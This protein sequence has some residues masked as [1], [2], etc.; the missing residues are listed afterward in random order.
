MISAMKETVS[1]QVQRDEPCVFCGA[2]SSSPNHA[3]KM[4]C[5]GT[6]R[7]NAKRIRDGEPLPSTQS[8]VVQMFPRKSP[9]KHCGTVESKQSF[10]AKE[11]CSKAC[12]NSAQRAAEPVTLYARKNPCLRCG[13]TIVNAEK[14]V[15]TEYCSSDCTHLAK[16]EARRL[17]QQGSRNM[18]Q[19]VL[20]ESYK[21]VKQKKVTPKPAAVTNK[22]GGRVQQN[23][24]RAGVDDFLC[25][26]PFK[27]AFSSIEKGDQFISEMHSGD[28]KMH[29]YPCR[30]GAVHIGH[31]G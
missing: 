6:C 9:C 7:K 14:M 1:L 17:P 24:K 25:P 12:K 16:L 22:Y 8:T 11:Y 2:L 20:A 18:Q 27:K 13:A 21:P 23:A 3:T 4:Y 10:V 15:N 5:S 26:T 29:A 19:Q 30:C 28:K 31:S